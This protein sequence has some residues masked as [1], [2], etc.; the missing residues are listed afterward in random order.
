[1]IGFVPIR[2]EDLVALRNVS[3]E[4][5]HRAARLCSQCALQAR[6]HTPTHESGSNS[7]MLR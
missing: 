6:K 4:K 2:D 3:I 5:E 7:K 1:M